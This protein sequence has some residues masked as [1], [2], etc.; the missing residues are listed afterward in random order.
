LAFQKSDLINFYSH[1][2]GAIVSLAG[3]VVLLCASAGSV[4][5]IVLSTIYSLC[6]VFIFICS[7]IYHGQKEE[8][9]DTNPWRKLDH[10]A[11]FFMIAGTY[12]PISYIYLDGYWRWGIIAA[13]WLLVVI[14]L[15]FKLVYIKGPRWL[16]AVIYVLMGWMALIALN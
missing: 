11:I 3:Y 14:G 16:T 5:K 15:I 2:A 8:Q 13:Q 10:I 6:A 12:T 1:L 7:S 4:P 9:D